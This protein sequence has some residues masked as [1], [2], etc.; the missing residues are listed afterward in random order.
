MKFVPLTEAKDH[1][2]ALADEVESTHEIVTV[3]RHGR[4]AVALVA[5]DDLEAM[6]ET[7]FW[8]SQP[9]I[10]DS[11]AEGDA[12]ID[13][14]RGVGLEQAAADLQARTAQGA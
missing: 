6:Q 8:L 2:S 5:V 1:L 9:G 13:A 14:G 12:A 7:I 3:T 10:R 4:P 11:I